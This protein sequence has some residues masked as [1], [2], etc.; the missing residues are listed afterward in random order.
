L[1]LGFLYFLVSG[2]IANGMAASK[3]I[4]HMDLGYQEVRFGNP[5][6]KVTTAGWLIPTS[7]QP[8]KGTLIAMHGG[9]QN[10]ADPTV[11]LLQLSRDVA[12]LGLN[13]LSLDRRGCG[14]SDTA[15]LNE[16]TKSDRDF[17]GAIDWVLSNNPKENILLF[18]TSFAGVAA[19]VQASKDSRVKGVVADSSFKNSMAMAVRCLH[20]TFPPFTIFATGSI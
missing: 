5:F 2:L 8:S 7:S 16:R 6:D 12:A 14:D 17:H 11:G 18:G 1:S 9:K 10:R 4:P 20:E 13:V 19:L 3:R 15:R